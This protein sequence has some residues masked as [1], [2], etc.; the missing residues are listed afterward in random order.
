MKKTNL[1]ILILILLCAF[2]TNAQITS[3]SKKFSVSNYF[4]PNNNGDYMRYRAH[5]FVQAHTSTSTGRLFLLPIIEK[6]DDNIEFVDENGVDFNPSSEPAKLSRT[7]IIPIKISSELPNDR[8][9]PAIASASG[10]GISILH[11]LSPMAKDNNGGFLILP[12]AIP[13][14][15]QL[16]TSAKKYQD[17]FEKQKKI[18]DLYK[19]YAVETVSINELEI[20]ASIDNEV[21][22]NIQISNTVLTSSGQLPSIKIVRPTL[23]QQNRI[24]RGKLEIKIAYKFRDAFTSTI[25][26]KFD[27]KEII[28]KFI[29]ET[30]NSS[31]SSSSSGWQILGF[32]NRRKRLKSSFNSTTQ[33]NYSGQKI[34]GTTIEMFDATDGMIAQFEN[35]FFPGIAKQKVIDNHTAAAQRAFDSGNNGLRDL[36]LKYADAVKNSDPDLEVNTAKAAAAL[37][38]KDYATFIA[39]GVRW[40]EHTATG[41]SSFRRVVRTKAEIDT[42]IDWS[43]MRTV[44]VQH[45]VSEF[46]VNFKKDKQKP[47]MGIGEAMQYNYPVYSFNSFGQVI[48]Q[49]MKNGIMASCIIDGSPVHQSGLIPGMIITAIGGQ[50]IT[51]GADLINLM[52]D[53]DP[54]DNINI[55]IIEYNGLQSR[56]RNISIT[57]VA[58]APK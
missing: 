21:I 26:A 19:N 55:S 3:N 20:T 35:D 4:Y 5:G 8:Q 56:K 16:E 15:F 57:L 24:I 10:N 40:G 27:A 12:K 25:S 44:S 46:L 49:E 29:S 6:D 37:A 2:S 51:N 45:A 9:L 33:K 48:N 43:Q 28:E 22:N 17:K 1:L 7:I 30:Q 58:G 38:K 52:K 11:Y 42:K 47:F 34:N 39:E 23:Y 53:Y 32:G 50:T 54:G 31:V 36:H 18:I 13:L 41:N 14:K